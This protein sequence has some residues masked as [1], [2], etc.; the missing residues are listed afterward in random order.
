MEQVR[1]DW[2]KYLGNFRGSPQS[3]NVFLKNNKKSIFDI[4]KVKYMFLYDIIV[5]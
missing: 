3:A 2:V 4:C 1:L 5:L